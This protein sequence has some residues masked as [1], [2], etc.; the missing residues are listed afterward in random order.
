[1][2]LVIRKPA[3]DKK[4]Q[5]RSPAPVGMDGR[6]AKMSQREAMTKPRMTM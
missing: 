2:S 3:A 5:N 6:A 4:R 1:M